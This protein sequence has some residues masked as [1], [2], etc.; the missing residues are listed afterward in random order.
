MTFGVLH[1]VISCEVISEQ[2]WPRAAGR[3]RAMLGGGAELAWPRQRPEPSSVREEPWPQTLLARVPRDSEP[4]EQVNIQ[5]VHIYI[6]LVF[7]AQS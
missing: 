7:S 6:I 1:L 4:F 5:T 2:P 3:V